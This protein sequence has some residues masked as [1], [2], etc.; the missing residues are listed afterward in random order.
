MNIPKDQN[1]TL[2][3][4]IANNFRASGLNE[5]QF[6]NA[7]KQF[8]F[9]SRTEDAFNSFSYME[10]EQYLLQKNLFGIRFLG[11]LSLI[12]TLSLIENV[13][14]LEIYSV[15]AHRFAKSNINLDLERLLFAKN[16]ILIATPERSLDLFL[17]VYSLEQNITLWVADP[18]LADLLRFDTDKK[19]NIAIKQLDL[20]FFEEVEIQPEKFN[21]IL[22]IPVMGTRRKYEKGRFVGNDTTTIAAEIL[23]ENNLEDFGTL[24]T[25]M[26]HKINFAQSEA[27][28]RQKYQQSLSRVQNLESG[29]FSNSSIKMYAYEFKKSLPDFIEVINSEDTTARLLQIQDVLGLDGIWD[30]EKPFKEED[31]EISSLLSQNHK[32]LQDV[33][34]IFRGKPLPKYAVGT[35]GIA[36]FVYIDMKG[37][38]D[39]DIEYSLTKKYTVDKDFSNEYLQEGDIL[40]QSKGNTSKVVTYEYN[41]ENCI[42]S[43]NLIVIR[44]INILP[45]YLLLFLRSEL[46]Q[47]LIKEKNRG[48]TLQFINHEDLK[49]IPI[50]VP[51]LD[52]QEELVN[53]YDQTMVDLLKQYAIIQ[54]KLD[55]AKQALNKVFSGQSTT[56]DVI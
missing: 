49:S 14:L 27:R 21:F 19:D 22:N 15:I 37:L 35:D 7:C 34:K 48:T 26:P 43:S 38:K 24:Y 30:F 16:N 18:L 40:I 47:K 17:Q 55:N 25:I 4:T 45:R 11:N 33:A 46:G 29:I 36:D 8:I 53:E 50:L 6:L 13:S 54:I 42:A 2:L 52:R 41:G 44:P 56:F 9:A 31:P 1:N 32:V 3:L 20:C 12:E 23:F 39:D 28:F 51:S 5:E 10:K